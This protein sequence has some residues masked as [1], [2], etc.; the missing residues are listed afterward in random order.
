MGSS[1]QLQGGQFCS[2]VRIGGPV[3]F[4]QSVVV[5]VVVGGMGFCLCSFST[6]VDTGDG[7]HLC[8]ALVF[9]SIGWAAIFL[10][11]W[12]A[13]L[14]LVFLAFTMTSVVQCH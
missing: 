4:P 5:A 2:V 8:R 10:V 13:L 14:I 6:A 3:W 1:S 9:F 7:G 12:H 11:G